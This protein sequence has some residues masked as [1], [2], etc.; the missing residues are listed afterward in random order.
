VLK[1]SANYQLALAQYSEAFEIGLTRKDVEERL[2]VTHTKFSQRCCVESRTAFTD[3]VKVGAEPAPWYC[4]EWPVYVAL[5]YSGQPRR[6]NT[7]LVP[8]ESDVLRQIAI[9]SYGEG[10]L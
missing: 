8:V 6:S 7:P 5:E 4:S 2:N 3:L 1:R 9:V 10:C